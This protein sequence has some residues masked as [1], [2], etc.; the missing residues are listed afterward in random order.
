MR[1]ERARILARHI[2]MRPHRI[3]NHS[4]C[5]HYVVTLCAQYQQKRYYL[6][7][8]IDIC[9]HARMFSLSL[10]A[11]THS[12]NMPT[13]TQVLSLSDE[14]VHKM[15]KNL[16]ITLMSLGDARHTINEHTHTHIHTHEHMHTPTACWQRQETSSLA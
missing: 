5:T 8:N 6:N 12:L 10:H 13:R 14:Q 4:V 11:D 9:R 15:C 7:L 2:R 16:Q 1:C 3:T